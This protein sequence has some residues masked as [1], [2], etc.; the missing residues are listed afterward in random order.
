MMTVGIV[1]A[2]RA[3]RGLTWVLAGMVA[4][5]GCGTS[6]ARLAKLRGDPMASFALPSAIETNTTEFVGGTSNASS[7]SMIRNTFTVPD[8]TAQDALVELAEAATA[9]GWALR[10]REPNGFAGEREIGGI[11]A[12][13]VIAGIEQDDT[14]WVV[15]SSRD[16]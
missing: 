1:R 12:Q 14:V 8:D 2:R 11:T 9:A 4:L 16:G 3:T 7:P 13:I 15:V 6:E 5:V 10:E